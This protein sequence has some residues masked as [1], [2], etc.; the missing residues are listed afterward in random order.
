MSAVVSTLPPPLHAVYGRVVGRSCE[1][2]AGGAVRCTWQVLFA[3]DQTPLH[4]VA[5]E[6]QPSMDST[7][8]GIASIDEAL[9]EAA[10]DPGV[11]AEAAVECHGSPP[12][13]GARV[14]A[15]RLLVAESHIPP[16]SVLG[17]LARQR[18]VLC[19]GT[20]NVGAVVWPRPMPAR[21]RRRQ[22]YPHQNELVAW[23][24]QR[25]RAWLGGELLD[26]SPHL[27]VGGTT[28][29]VGDEGH[30]GVAAAPPVER[31]TPVHG[32]MIVH[33]CNSGRTEAVLGLIGRTVR[34]LGARAA[35]RGLRRA[36]DQARAQLIPS[37]ATL[38]LVNRASVD[39]W[40]QRA[41]SRL[42]G[43]ISVV[44]IRSVRDWYK[45]TGAQLCEADV[46][47]TSPATLESDIYVQRLC[48]EV[49]TLGGLGGPCAT[50][51]I[52]LLLSRSL[53]CMHVAGGG[54]STA[55]APAPLELFAWR[56]IVVEDAHLY[57][58][59]ALP[60]C[61][62]RLGAAVTWVI[63][64][65]ATYVARYA[66]A[67]VER[68]DGRGDADAVDPGTRD[69]FW[70]ECVHMR[71]IASPPPRLDQHVV[72]VDAETG[73]DIL[74]QT[75]GVP[76][77]VPAPVPVD[78]AAANAQLTVERMVAT[79]NQHAERQRLRAVHSPDLTQM[80]QIA[81]CVDADRMDHLARRRAEQLVHLQRALD[82]PIQECPVCMEHT[83]AVHPLC[84][85]GLCAGCMRRIL[86]APHVACPTCRENIN[87][88]WLWHVSDGRPTHPVCGPRARA[89]LTIL[90][91]A[92]RAVVWFPSSELA[93]AAAA[94]LRSHITC[95]RVAGAASARAAAFDALRTGTPEAPCAVLLT[96]LTEHAG[97]PCGAL[98]HVVI[99]APLP[100][101]LHRRALSYARSFGEEPRPLVT[102]L[103]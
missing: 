83:G 60:A 99:Y 46:V 62:S 43:P 52:D 77:E 66:G 21:T 100:P 95:V 27:R 47:V 29:L 5:F 98:T 93:R 26:I 92:P 18:R 1:H 54:R 81:L 67:L 86:T 42:E 6:T 8:C 9:T 37:R 45:L 64:D 94:V 90:R 44:E 30:Y 70:R 103:I 10:A 56:R 16:P 71:C 48:L 32:G 4:M 51:Q 101:P 76:T 78:D 91:E 31:R 23:M 15:A 96:P 17:I 33:E 57:G 87:P 19:S 22:L 25:E 14:V 69:A 82:Q 74:L 12:V 34:R 49:G 88:E 24:E 55:L 41:R 75:T 68:L 63:A 73:G 85:H 89:L 11:T 20:P 28:L 39:T 72:P 53:A 65:T 50:G 40:A 7:R 36:R 61:L 3:E 13:A 102:A 97:I 38:V 80:Q 58:A 2:V 79:L 59:E 84:G 35:E